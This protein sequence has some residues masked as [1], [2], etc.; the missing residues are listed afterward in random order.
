MPLSTNH[1]GFYIS[2]DQ[3]QGSVHRG[4][5]VQ[6]RSAASSPPSWEGWKLGLCYTGQN[7]L[8][9]IDHIH[10]LTM[11]FMVSINELFQQCV[12]KGK[13]NTIDNIRY[14]ILFSSCRFT[15]TFCY[16]TQFSSYFL[17]HIHHFTMFFS[18]QYKRTVTTV[19]TERKN[20][21][22]NHYALCIIS[23]SFIPAGLL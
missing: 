12:L 1:R 19:C 4:R 13:T 17:Y 5:V 20:K 6:G 9:L 2:I 23:Y 11:F 21:Y 8:F 14:T 10:H 18:G 22:N 7:V 15:I 3:W 16:L